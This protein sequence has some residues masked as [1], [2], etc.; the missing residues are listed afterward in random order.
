MP[1]GQIVDRD[2]LQRFLYNKADSRGVLEMTQYDIAEMLHLN[3]VSVSRLF[4]QMREEGRM[5]II[6]RRNKGINVYHILDP[7][8]DDS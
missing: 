5:K 2:K 7:D 3:Y 1:R 4:K 6:G 8:E